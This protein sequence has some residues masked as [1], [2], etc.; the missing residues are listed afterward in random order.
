MRERTA[1][2]ASERPN[3]MLSGGIS[4]IAC[5]NALTEVLEVV[6]VMQLLYKLT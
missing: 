2:M 1:C 6:I 3:T 5:A 4:P